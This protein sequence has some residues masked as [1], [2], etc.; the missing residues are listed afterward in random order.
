M[1][2]WHHNRLTAIYTLESSEALT[3]Q[4]VDLRQINHMN[5]ICLLIGSLHRIH[6]AKMF[7]R[8]YERSTRHLG[9]GGYYFLNYYIDILSVISMGKIDKNKSCMIW[10]RTISGN[11]QER[12]WSNIWLIYH[13]L[14]LSC[15][16]TCIC[17]HNAHPDVVIKH[18]H[19]VIH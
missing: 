11:R 8:R 6:G 12:Q 10:M 15:I 3:K 5:H 9:F 19:E 14:A 17:I 1:Y 16:S 2:G 18:Q 4:N 7:G 13:I